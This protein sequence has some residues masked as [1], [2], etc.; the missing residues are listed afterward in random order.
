V[1]LA[2]RVVHF[3]ARRQVEW[4]A[5]VARALE[6]IVRSLDERDARAAWLEERL[7]GAE[8]RIAHMEAEVRAMREAEQDARKKL[9]AMGIAL[10]ELGAQR[11][12]R[13]P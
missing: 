10:S 13:P 6:A 8:E 5:T 9:A 4:N 11:T 1:P 3:F 2:A 7:H 12:D